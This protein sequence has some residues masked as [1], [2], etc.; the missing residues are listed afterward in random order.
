MG[1]RAVEPDY[2]SYCA[3]DEERRKTFPAASHWIYQS[4]LGGQKVAEWC[5]IS[6]VCRVGYVS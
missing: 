4:R 3:W 5:A 1:N 2:L 6:G